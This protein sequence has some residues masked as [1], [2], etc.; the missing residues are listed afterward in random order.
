MAE[1]AE[2][3]P[4]W[5]TVSALA[6]ARDVDKAGISRRVARLEAAG[7]LTTRA[8]ERGTKLINIAEFTHA[9]AMTTDAVREAN[10][11]AA[12]PINR[13]AAETNGRRSAAASQVAEADMGDTPSDPILAREQARK[14]MLAADIAQ[15]QLDELKGLLVRAADIDAGAA[16]QGETLARRIDQMLPEWADELAAVVAKDGTAGLRAALKGKAREL[17]GALA[18]AFAALASTPAHEDGNRMVEL[19]AEAAA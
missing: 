2:D 16:M 13:M 18:E 1:L 14:T 6:R 5:L 7:A 15:L 9:I 17:R 3:T 19:E 4:E 8:G 12:S 11:R 10:G